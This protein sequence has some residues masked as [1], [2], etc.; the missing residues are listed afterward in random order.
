[1]VISFSAGQ[2][3]TVK[4]PKAV[5]LPASTNRLL[6]RGRLTSGRCSVARKQSLPTSMV[7]RAGSAASCSLNSEKA[8]SPTAKVSRREQLAMVRKP[9]FFEK[10]SWSTCSDTSASRPTTVSSSASTKLP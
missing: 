10:L 2:S 9:W 5:K 6:S 4:E 1:M 3:C 7:C 8:L